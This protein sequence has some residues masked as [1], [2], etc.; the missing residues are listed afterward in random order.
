M[1]YRILVLCI[2][3]LTSYETVCQSIELKDHDR[4]DIKQGIR[5]LRDIKGTCTFEDI[6]KTGMPVQKERVLNYGFD[7]AVHW[8]SFELSNNSPNEDWLL[9]IPFAPLDQV[10]FYIGHDTT[11]IHKTAGDQLP[12]S[13]RDIL[14]PHP[15]FLFPVPQG[16]VRT[17]YLRVKTTSSV[18]IPVVVWKHDLFITKSISLQIINGLL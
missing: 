4:I 5:H 8:V 14:Y 1:T 9:E 11:W 13:V 6:L 15:V 7:H 16:S 3:V 18:Q 17:V 10:D 2:L 12:M